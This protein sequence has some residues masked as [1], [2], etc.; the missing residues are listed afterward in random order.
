MICVLEKE[1]IVRL[2]KLRCRISEV[3]VVDFMDDCR[4]FC[5]VLIIEIFLK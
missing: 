4:L 5:I 2:C 3:K 1:I